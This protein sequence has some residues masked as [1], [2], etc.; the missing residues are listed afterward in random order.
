MA[1]GHSDALG[2]IEHISPASRLMRML[3]EDRSDLLVLLVYTILTGLI[4]LAVPLAAQA[5]VNTIAAGLFVQPL[6]VLTL[7][8]FAAMLLAGALRLVQMSLVE[9]LQQRIFAR[10]ALQ[11]GQR[12]PRIRNTA[13]AQAYAPEL[14]NRFFDVLTVQ[15]TLSK[16]LLDGLAAALTTSSG[17]VLLAFYDSSGALLGF[18]LFIILFA[19]FVL[20][21]LGFGGLRTSIHESVQKYR[22]AE[23]LEELAR[24]QTSFK[25]DGTRHFQVERTDT[26][27]VGYIQARRSHFAVLLRQ[28][29]GSYL[30][31]AL[32][33]AGILGIG[34]AMVINRQ[35]TLGQLVA[36]ELIVLSVLAS[37]DKLVKQSEQFFD[38]LT[39]LDKIGHVTD[40]PIERE[41]GR[42][43]P[44][45]AQGGVVCRGV[46]FSYLPG[47]EILADLNLSV[48]PGERVSLVGA[49]GAGKSTLAALLCGLEEPSHGLVEV[50]GNEVRTSDL[51]SLRSLV[52]LVGDANEIYDGT[53]EENI[54]V[55]R[56]NLSGEDIRRAIAMAQLTDDLA[57]LPLGLATPL[58]S[59]GKNLS[60]GQ[61]QRLLIARAIVDSPQLL[62]LDEAFIGIDE[63]TKLK[64]LDAVYAPENRWT[65]I[66]ISHD[67]EVVL[68]S[69]TVHVLS[70]GR[71]VETGGPETLALQEASEFAAL[72]P[73]LAQQIRVRRANGGNAQ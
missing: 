36:A 67:A 6:V 73:D 3:W 70:G 53:I 44:E 13:L 71:I 12:I 69:S 29:C 68:R 39:G 60:R 1:G 64:I 43:L 59:A 38:L 26:L 27:V 54:S 10:V 4:G 47:M 37:L 9:V 41:G 48:Q 20:F 22:V 42:L 33:S 25:M 5:L 34:G 16:L 17:L 32:A 62:I 11:L 19:L 65:I 46:R 66:D 23:W 49:S 30:F 45:G 40:L 51:D 21:I 7:G 8:V 24:C 52:A 18:D 57:K 14:V 58:V 31:Q 35:L 56:A 2:H 72:F 55:G 61:I 50:C 15:K 63:R 28:A